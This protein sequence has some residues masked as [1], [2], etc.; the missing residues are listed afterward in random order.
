MKT[1]AT[2]QDSS[3]EG[4]FRLPAPHGL[5]IELTG[6]KHE[7]LLFWEWNW[8]NNNFLRKHFINDDEIEN[9]ATKMPKF[10]SIQNAFIEQFPSI[11]KMDNSLILG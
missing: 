3:L 4:S 11:D 1:K 7:F 8:T 5:R 9:S 6:K 10:F 2:N